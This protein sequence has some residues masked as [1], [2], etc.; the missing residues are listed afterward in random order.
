MHKI[1]RKLREQ[2]YYRD[3]RCRV[4]GRFLTLETMHPHHI[5]TVG[6]GGEDTLE[7]LIALCGPHHD[8]V[9]R[10]SVTLDKTYEL[11][12]DVLRGLIGLEENETARE[13]MSRYADIG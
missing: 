1:S 11:N 2:L 3:G 7:N 9:H 10:G 5:R 6:A 4:C 8:A 13:I 12:Q